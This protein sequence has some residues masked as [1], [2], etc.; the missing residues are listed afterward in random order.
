[1]DALCTVRTT[2]VSLQQWKN[3]AAKHGKTLSE[4]VR[5]YLNEQSLKI[6]AKQ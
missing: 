1:M 3:T 5:E 2:K 6:N 4:F